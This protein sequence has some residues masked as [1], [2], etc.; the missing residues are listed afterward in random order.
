MGGSIFG[1]RT[2]DLVGL[3]FVG[4]IESAMLWVNF[5]TGRAN[6]VFRTNWVFHLF[7]VGKIERVNFRVKT[8]QQHLNLDSEAPTWTPHP[9]NLGGDVASGSNFKGKLRSQYKP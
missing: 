5:G 4:K 9:P 8:N 1:G 3:F 7:F 6:F 2:H